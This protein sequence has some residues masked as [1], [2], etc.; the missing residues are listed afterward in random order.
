LFLLHFPLVGGH[1]FEKDANY[2]WIYIGA[3]AVKRNVVITIG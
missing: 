2:L 3:L 1:R